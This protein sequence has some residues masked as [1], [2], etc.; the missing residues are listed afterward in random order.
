MLIVSRKNRT[1]K[2]SCFVFGYLRNDPIDMK[3]AVL[4]PVFVPNGLQNVSDAIRRAAVLRR[5]TARYGITLMILKSSSPS[6]PS[7]GTT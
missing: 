2:P 3:L 1:A 4:M 6:P 7:C 5:N